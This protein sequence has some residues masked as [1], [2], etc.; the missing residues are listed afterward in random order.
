M[1]SECVGL[2][3]AFEPEGSLK[4]G[5]DRLRAKKTFKFYAGESRQL[6]ASSILEH[7]V[8]A[9]APAGD[10]GRAKLR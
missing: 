3:N 2:I 10:E 5:Q 4:T 6:Q 8:N 9:L 1:T 7:I